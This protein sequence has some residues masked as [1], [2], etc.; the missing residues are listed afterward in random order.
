MS[1]KTLLAAAGL[2]EDALGTAE[3]DFDLRGSGDTPH[4]IAANGTGHLGIASVNGRI[5]GRVLAVLVADPLRRA[6]LPAPRMSGQT[7]LRCLAG[8]VEMLRGTASVRSFFLDSGDAQLGGAGTIGL[9]DETVA[10]T[11]TPVVRGSGSGGVPLRLSGPIRDPKVSVLGGSD[12]PDGF[13][14]QLPRRLIDPDAEAC[15]QPLAIARDG[16]PGPMPAS[17]TSLLPPPL[18]PLPP[19]ASPYPQAA[20]IPLTPA[21]P[22]APARAPSGGQ[23][24]PIDLFQFMR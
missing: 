18:R 7:D 20:P 4:A 15:T 6:G 3:V 9:G 12:T 23:Q 11:L 8:R 24:K 2:P 22:S 21:P 1:L 13:Q 17:L 16:R 10:L 19:L 5:G 14:A